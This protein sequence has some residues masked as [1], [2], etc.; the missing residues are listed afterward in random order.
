MR[1]RFRLKTLMKTLKFFY[2]W[3]SWDNW[4]LRRDVIRYVEKNMNTS[5]VYNIEFTD[6]TLSNWISDVEMHEDLRGPISKDW[7]SEN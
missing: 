3:G 6:G 7:D 4:I 5:L 2:S 1:K